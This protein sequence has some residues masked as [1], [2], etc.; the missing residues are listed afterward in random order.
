MIL[1]RTA[2]AV[3]LA[4]TASLAGLTAPAMA[5]ESD[6]ITWS[7]R[8]GDE[9]GA[10]GRSW[11]EHELD[12]GESI[13]EHLVV[14]NHGDAAVAF[15][16]N[17]ADGYFTDKG[18]FNIL[19][20][21][22]TSTDA[23]TWI[24]LS[25]QSVE[26]G[27]G[28]SESVSFRI[29]V[30]DD[31]T[32]GDHPAGVSASVLLD[33]AGEVKV[34]SRVGFRVMSRVT[35]ELHSVAVATGAG[36]FTGSINPFEPGD[37]AVHYSVANEGNTRL[38]VQ[39]DVTLTAPFGLWSTTVQ[40][41]ALTEIA[42]GERRDGTIAVP[43]IWPAFLYTIDVDTD[44]APVA[45]GL[46]IG[47]VESPGTTVTAMAIPWSQL[48][49]LVLIAGVWTLWHI[50]RR[51]KKNLIA[52]LSAQVNAQQA[53]DA[54]ASSPAAS[55]VAPSASAAV[56]IAAGVVAA[57][58]FVVTPAQ[59]GADTAEDPGGVE[60]S[61]TIDENSGSEAPEEPSPQGPDGPDALPATGGDSTAALL[62]S[63]AA[64]ALLIG[65]ATLFR[66]SSRA[67]AR[68]K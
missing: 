6:V 38:Q 30:P 55:R 67:R 21:G 66:R 59:A 2:T 48:V 29:T 42:P 44:V 50:D 39:P 16:L 32:P 43:G 15:R 54:A 25:T 17:A 13:V 10:D 37:M 65:G 41:Q 1:A 45:D 57:S 33:G 31:A 18:R 58:L 60:I 26:V 64:G 4:L 36:S 53:A 40:G 8:P 3:L 61:V 49:A 68:L 27:P 5:A 9:S 34:D 22:G 52:Q 47:T 23:G 19:P 62:L 46:E 56:F 35:G 28:A 24:E 14:T 12:P 20:V 11:I 51:R 63:G 7:V